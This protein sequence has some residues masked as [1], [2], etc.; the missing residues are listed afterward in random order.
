MVSMAFSYKQEQ[1]IKKKKKISTSTRNTLIFYSLWGIQEHCSLEINSR[2]F[3]LVWLNWTN[4]L[5]HLGC[6]ENHN[7]SQYLKSDKT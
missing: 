1:N 4:Y 7:I 6:R 2:H 3:G 5:L